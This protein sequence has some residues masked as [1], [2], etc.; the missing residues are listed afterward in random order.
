LKKACGKYFKRH[1]KSTFSRVVF[2][3]LAGLPLSHF[4]QSSPRTPENFFD[5]LTR[6]LET[7]KIEFK[8]PFWS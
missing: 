2:M 7:I 5:R 1:E 3:F 4:A 6:Q 8:S